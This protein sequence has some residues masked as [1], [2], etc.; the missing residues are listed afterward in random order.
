VGSLE[1]AAKQPGRHLHLAK[2]EMLTPNASPPEEVQRW[3][4]QCSL[5]SPGTP[6]PN[7]RK[8]VNP[9]EKG[10]EEAIMGSQC[11]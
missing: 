9:E 8:Q 10:I 6:A 3:C 4:G 5:E 2:L 1:R 11:F 7:K